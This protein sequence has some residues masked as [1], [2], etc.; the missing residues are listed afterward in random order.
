MPSSRDLATGV[1]RCLHRVATSAVAGMASRPGPRATLVQDCSRSRA[2]W[3][4]RRGTVAVMTALLAVPLIGLSALAVDVGVWMLNKGAMQGAADQAV[5][6]AALARASGDD[7]VREARSIAAAHG[8]VHNPAGGSRATTVVVGRPTAGRL[9]ATE[10]ALEVVITQP[11]QSY[12]S[13]VIVGFTAPV[14]S[15]RS[16]AAP[17]GADTCIVALAPSGTS[18]SVNHTSS[19][20][21]NG[22]NVYVNSTSSCALMVNNV[23]RVT[24]ADMFLGGSAGCKA[25]PSTITGQQH[26]SSPPVKDPYRLRAMPTPAPTPACTPIFVGRYSP[27]SRPPGT[28][29]S[30]YVTEQATLRLSS[31][32]YIID[33]GNVEVDN[34]SSIIGDDVTIILTSRNGIYKDVLISNS[35]NVK[36]TAMKKGPT[37]GIA[38]WI[39]GRGTGGVKVNV[40]T[41]AVTGAIYAPNAGVTWDNV[42]YGSSGPCTQLV[43]RTLSFDSTSSSTFRHE[44]AG[45]GVETVPTRLYSLKE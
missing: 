8:F 25:F 39:D 10:D 1:R 12:L 3:P 13:G 17:V 11:Q 44:C 15:A 16:V 14:A 21:S 5:L 7:P 45:Y 24:A 27:P 35:S 23:S 42:S 34:Q 19:V 30:I 32:I 41:L 20:T 26:V 22:C 43:V 4:G 38:L 31:G 2:S 33:G 37:R 29:C 40:S 18:F 36:I 9:N 28:Y 6:A